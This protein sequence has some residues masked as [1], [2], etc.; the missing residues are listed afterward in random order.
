MFC[1]KN[2]HSK[3]ESTYFQKFILIPFIFEKSS[4]KILLPKSLKV[5]L[6]LAAAEIKDAIFVALLESIKNAIGMISTFATTISVL[7]IFK[8]KRT[9]LSIITTW[10][11]WGSLL[12]QSP[13][14]VH[15]YCKCFDKHNFRAFWSLHLRCNGDTLADCLF[16][17]YYVQNSA[18]SA[19]NGWKCSDS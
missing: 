2:V 1:R 8:R 15:Y 5:L 16:R 13:L 10:T 14:S 9:L 6:I 7:L 18:I 17:L 4:K 11:L 12:Y 3:T 19:R